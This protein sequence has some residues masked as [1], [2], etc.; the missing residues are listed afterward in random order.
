MPISSNTRGSMVKSPSVGAADAGEA[1]A[2]SEKRARRA[3]DAAS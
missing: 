2:G 3:I 1:G